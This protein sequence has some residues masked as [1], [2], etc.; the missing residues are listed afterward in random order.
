MHPHNAH[1]HMYIP[2]FTNTPTHQHLFSHT[3]PLTHSSH[4]TY[5]TPHFTPHSAFLYTTISFSINTPHF[6]T[7]HFP[8]TPLPYTHQSVLHTTNLSSHATSIFNTQQSL[9]AQ[10][11]HTHLTHHAPHFTHTHTSALSQRLHT[12]PHTSK[13]PP[14]C[15]SQLQILGRNIRLPHIWP[16]TV[17]LP[18]SNDN[19]IFIHLGCRFRTQLPL[20]YPPLQPP[21]HP[22]HPP[23]LASLTATFPTKTSSSSSTLTAFK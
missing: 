2:Y 15:T 8:H 11:H 22:F 23:P 14:H 12:P 1:Q 6:S 18:C 17:G 4:Y 13:Y 5:S 3:P 9:P 7:P 10:T 21:R 19:S 20:F 16:T